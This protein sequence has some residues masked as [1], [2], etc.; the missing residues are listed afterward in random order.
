MYKETYIEALKCHFGSD[1]RRINHALKV[2]AFAEQ[3]MD[4]ESISK[5]L[6]QIVTMTAIL[7]DVGIKIAEQKYGSSAG[8]YQEQEGPPVAAAIMRRLGEN[9]AVIDRVCYIIGGHHTPA[10]NDGLDFQ[11][12]WEADLFVN[13]EE[14]GLTGDKDKLKII[15]AKN[16]KTVTGKRLAEEIYLA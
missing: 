4:G 7:H 5:N 15:L 1:S 8:P 6:R 13:I 12:I 16:F 11:I 3:I 2:L 10:K 9:E 14:E